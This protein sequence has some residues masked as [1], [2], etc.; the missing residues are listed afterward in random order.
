LSF[1]QVK[2]LT[3]AGLEENEEFYDYK[4]N[5]LSYFLLIF[6]YYFSYDKF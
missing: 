5:F 4:D 3:E 1:K 6:S 2:T